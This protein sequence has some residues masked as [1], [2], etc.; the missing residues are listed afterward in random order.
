MDTKLLINGEFVDG[1]EAAEAVLNPRTGETILDLLEASVEQVPDAV[2]PGCFC[3][4]ITCR[5]R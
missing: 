4:C 1:T 3:G 2:V 5:V